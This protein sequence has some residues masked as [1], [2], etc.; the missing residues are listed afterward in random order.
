[1]GNTV[2]DWMY[3]EFKKLKLNLN[4]GFRFRTM[5]SKSFTK[6]QKVIGLLILK[7]ICLAQG[8]KYSTGCF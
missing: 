1:M 3:E 6:I 5:K 2:E 4:S 7:Y 8:S